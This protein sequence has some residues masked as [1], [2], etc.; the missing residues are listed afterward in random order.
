[1]VI[2]PVPEAEMPREILDHLR[3]K[4]D[5][6]GYLGAFFTHMAHQPDAL[7]AF[8]RFTSAVKDPLDPGLVEVV[9]LTVATTAGNAYER[10]QHERLC[11]NLGFGR[12]WIAEVEALRPDDAT[13][14]T[15]AQLAVQRLAIAMTARHGRDTAAERDRVVELLGA[16]DT[17]GIMFL[18]GRYLT[19]AQIVNTLELDPP[20][21]SVFATEAADAG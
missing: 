5:R 1:M 13:L 14:L 2:A 6:L 16:Q 20:V 12:A 21:P 11:V 8:L 7:L 18:V 4:I 10:N 15:S 9:A 17:V 19:H 3:S